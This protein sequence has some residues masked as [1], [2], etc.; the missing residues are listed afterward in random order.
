M[1]SKHSGFTLIELLV[2]VAVVGVLAAIAVPQ[3]RSYSLRAKVAEALASAGA[4]KTAVSDYLSSNNT[5]PTDLEASGCRSYGST[6][7]VGAIDVVDGV[8]TVT[9]AT[10]GELGTASGRS[11]TM[12]PTMNGSNIITQWKCEPDTLPPS[13]VPGSC[14]S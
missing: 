6:Q 11:L 10:L 5:L 13:L 1:Q 2:T 7:Y 9:M 3:Y 8:I 4:C 12:T 14:R